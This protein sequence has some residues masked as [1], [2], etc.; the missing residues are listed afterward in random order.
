MDEKL[1]TPKE[2]AEYLRVSVA[3]LDWLRHIG[4]GPKYFKV[5]RR[6]VYKESAITDYIKEQE[7]M[8]QNA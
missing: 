2:V 6:V 7:Q 8:A 4:T 5:G 3:T 1:L